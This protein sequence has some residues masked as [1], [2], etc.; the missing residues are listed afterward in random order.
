MGD[1]DHIDIARVL[2]K[3]VPA[4]VRHP[5]AAEHLP[6][7]EGLQRFPRIPRQVGGKA[8]LPAG[9]SIVLKA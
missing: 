5:L 4:D 7:A 3:G 1:P 6:D 9:Q 8:G 2:D